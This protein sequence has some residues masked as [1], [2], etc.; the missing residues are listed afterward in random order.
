MEFL[1]S[2]KILVALILAILVIGSFAYL[3][4]R[5]SRDSGDIQDSGYTNVSSFEANEMINSDNI[6]IL[7]VRSQSEYEKAHIPNAIVFPLQKLDD[8]SP[9]LS[10]RQKILVY[11]DGQ[12]SS[13]ACEELV[14]KGYENVHNLE[15][16]IS[17]WIENDYEIIKPSVKETVKIEEGDIAPNFKLKVD[18]DVFSL[19]D[20]QEDIIL[21][22]FL[23][24]HCGACKTEVDELK[25]ISNDYPKLTI[26]SIGKDNVA[27]Q[28]LKD[29]KNAGWSFVA[30][31][32]LFEDYGVE[33]YPT[34]FIIGEGNVVKFKHP[35]VASYGEISNEL[36]D[37]GL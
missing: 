16:G 11:G 22:D 25:K 28:Q 21:L 1:K 7:D 26:L 13:T 12:E 32:A 33:T 18:G 17:A 37:L 30:N 4:L 35:G 3:Q 2:K 29:E 19:I 14:K 24:A 34:I 23:S 8:N 5:E 27:L 20:H 6:A 15:G 31:Q 36:E 9:N 10:K